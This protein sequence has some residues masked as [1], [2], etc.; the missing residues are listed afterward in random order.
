MK[1]SKEKVE[2]HLRIIHT[3][4]VKDESILVPTDIPPISPLQHQFNIS[5]PKLS[6]V[7]E[8]VK[9]ASSA[10]VLGPNGVPY[11]VYK[12]APDVLNFL[13]R[14]ISVTWEKQ[15]IPKAWQRAGEC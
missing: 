1:A 11:C 13:W 14:N 3:D 4:E 12:N 10:S 15:V 7:K 8:V 9:K 5:P 2:E 6:E